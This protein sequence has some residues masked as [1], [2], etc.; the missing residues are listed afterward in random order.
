MTIIEKLIKKIEA[1][2]WN[3]KSDGNYYTIGKFSNAGQ[4]FSFNID[5]SDF[6]EEDDN[7]A[8]E[9]FIEAI[10]GE[11]DEYDPSYEAYLWL[12]NTG[13]GINGAPYEMI[14]VYNDMVECQEMIYELYN[15]LRDYY[16]TEF[17][18]E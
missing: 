8:A 11:Y 9:L 10:H 18:T 13:H 7:T 3:I 17:Y 16:Y 14:D 15:E 4:D 12:D 6:L 2:D 5:I 1:L